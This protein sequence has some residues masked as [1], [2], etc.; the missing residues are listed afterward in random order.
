MISRYQ[1]TPCDGDAPHNKSLDASGGSVFRNLFGMAESALMRAAASTQT[2]G[3]T[4]LRNSYE[5]CSYF[6][7]CVNAGGRFL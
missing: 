4:F 6:T 1:A 3:V 2:L 5:H 7:A